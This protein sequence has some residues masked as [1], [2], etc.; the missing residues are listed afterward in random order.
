MRSFALAGAL[1][2]AALAGTLPA[3]TSTVLSE[4]VP[5]VESPYPLLAISLP[6]QTLRN[7]EEQGDFE[8][9][10]A[11][12]Q[13]Y[14]RALIWG[15]DGEAAALAE[16]RLIRVDSVT[17]EV[18]VRESPENVERVRR[19]INPG[20]AATLRERVL[21]GP[22]ASQISTN[23]FSLPPDAGSELLRRPTP[24]PPEPTAPDQSVVTS[25]RRTLSLDRTMTFRDLR[26]TLIDVFVSADVNR[27]NVVLLAETPDNSQEFTI[28][29]RQSTTFENYRIRVTDADPEAQ[30]ATVEVTYLPGR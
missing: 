24:R 15:Q 3:G 28:V 25:T 30:R 1:A 4:P 8:Q 10:A 20:L 9:Q 2:A 6:E 5:E 17:G 26:I 27:P 14:L 16:G 23:T 11:R 7:W 18:L 21:T 22:S 12:L 19:E 29:E 13:S